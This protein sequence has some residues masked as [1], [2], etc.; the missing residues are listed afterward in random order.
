MENT[1]L[2]KLET[3]ALESVWPHETLNFTP[4]LGKPENIRIL[5]DTLGVELE[6]D[7]QE[8]AVGPFAAD[9]V[10]KNTADNSWVLIEN[11]IKKTDHTHLGQ[12]L[13]YASGLGAKTMVWIAAKFT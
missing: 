10:C 3:V 11:Q 7:D 8:V 9:I 4:W 13:T 6:M 2:G 5:G 12:I 1:P